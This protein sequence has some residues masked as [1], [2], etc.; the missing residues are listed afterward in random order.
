MEDEMRKIMAPRGIRVFLMLILIIFCWWCD[1]VVAIENYELAD[2]WGA[3][4][5]GDGE[6]IEP[7]GIA[8]DDEANVYVSDAVGNHRIQKFTSDGEFITKWGNPGSGDGEFNAPWGLDVDRDGNVYVA[9]MWNDRIQKFSSDGEY[10]NQWNTRVGA[11]WQLSLPRAV[12]VDNEGFVYVHHTSVT[13]PS[14]VYG[15]IQKFTSDGIYIE[16]WDAFWGLG[17]YEIA[18]DGSGN[19]YV[20]CLFMGPLQSFSSEGKLIGSMIACTAKDGLCSTTGI[21]LDNE[22]NV[23]VSDSANHSIAKFA[24][25]GKLITKW[26]LKKASGFGSPPSPAGLAIDEA[27]NVYVVD[28]GNSLIQKYA[29][30]SDTTTT[31]T[32]TNCP[33]V[34]ALHGNSY[35]LQTLREFRDKVLATSSRGNDY[36]NSYYQHAHE[37]IVVLISDS[38]LR[39]KTEKVLTG[40]IPT[41]ESILNGE[42]VVLST[43]L[44]ANIEV[45]INELGSK[46]SPSLQIEISKI[47]REIRNRTLFE[48][49][50][51]KHV[52]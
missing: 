12:A 33:S 48:N 21:A 8:V 11:L 6:F 1:L 15:C 52:K 46:A 16:K 42:E 29:K 43:E 36:I 50:G 34:I 44:T 40:L 18:T 19:V 4:G 41:I 13:F 22:D 39:S 28:T 10:I 49:L 5:N 31:T 3:E 17:T 7:Y 9:D 23:Y 25:D 14:I 20:P 35:Q 30:V 27:G 26:E 51:I 45:F 37:L 47:Q 38:R 32:T 2:E 24:P